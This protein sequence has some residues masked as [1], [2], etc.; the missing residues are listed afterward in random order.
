MTKGE[1][2]RLDVRFN[3]ISSKLDVFASTA[4]ASHMEVRELITECRACRGNVNELR[5]VV[6]GNG[7]PGLKGNRGPTPSGD[8]V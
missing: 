3:E 5:N 1:N 6:F 4:Q 7:N 2:D 8:S